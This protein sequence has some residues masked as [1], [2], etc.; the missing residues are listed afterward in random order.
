M[1][2]PKFKVL[3]TNKRVIVGSGINADLSKETVNR[4]FMNFINLE[5]LKLTWEPPKYSLV[6]MLGAGYGTIILDNGKRKLKLNCVEN[7][8]EV[9][10]M[11][12]GVSRI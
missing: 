10:K 3:V 11:I 4:A 2:A 6:T 12:E 1:I 9:V 5:D 7:A 8:R